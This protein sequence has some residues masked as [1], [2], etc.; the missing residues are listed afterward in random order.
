MYKY[1]DIVIRFE[2]LD[3][4]IFSGTCATFVSGKAW[5]TDALEAVII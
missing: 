5:R 4:I 1:N 2:Y 3:W